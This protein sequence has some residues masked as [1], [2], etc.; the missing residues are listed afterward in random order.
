MANLEN[1]D[2]KSLH[3]LNKTELIRIIQEMARLHDEL[4]ERERCKAA[5]EKAVLKNEGPN[6]KLN[7]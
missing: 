6:N 4:M 1:W 5:F 2:G 3:S 7:G